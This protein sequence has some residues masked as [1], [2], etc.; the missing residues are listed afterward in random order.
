MNKKAF[1][2]TE[3]VVSALFLTLI[4]GAM[5]TS[6]VAVRSLL[7]RQIHRTQAFNFANETYKRLRSNYEYTSPEL[8]AGTAYSGAE[9]GCVVEGK[10]AGLSTAVTYDVEDSEPAGYKKITVKVN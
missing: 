4:A 1:T 2:L 9:I 3:I 5:L 7:N 8:N 10:M 6:F